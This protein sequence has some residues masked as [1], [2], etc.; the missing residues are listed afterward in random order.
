MKK[1]VLNLLV[2]ALSVGFF[3]C[4][5]DDEAPVLGAYVK[6]TVVNSLG[7]PQPDMDVYMFTNVE[8]NEETDLSTAS[9][10]VKTNADGVAGFKLNLTELNIT[11]SKTPLYFA[12]YY[13][14]GNDFMLKAGEQ[15]V[16]VKRDEEKDIT[17]TIP[18]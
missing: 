10:K 1:L 11:E 13:K 15:S 14:V 3:S 12:V 5:D 17:I 8:P 18:L 2:I 16:T 6:V 7:I 9:E 4:S